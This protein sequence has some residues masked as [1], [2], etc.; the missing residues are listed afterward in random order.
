MPSNAVEVA[1]ASTATG[2]APTA[3]VTVWM[4]K[5]TAQTR[6]IAVAVSIVGV[7]IL[8]SLWAFVVW[9]RRFS[10]KVSPSIGFQ[11]SLSEERQAFRTPHTWEET[12]FD[13]HSARPFLNRPFSDAWRRFYPLRN[14][15][16]VPEP[17]IE[18][19]ASH[20][21]SLVE[22][23]HDDFQADADKL[24]TLDAAHTVYVPAPDDSETGPDV[25]KPLQHAG[26]HPQLVVRIPERAPSQA[27]VI[28]STPS[29]PSPLPPTPPP[30][31]RHEQ[32]TSGK[33]P[34]SDGAAKSTPLSVRQ[35]V[36]SV[37]TMPSRLSNTA[38][39]PDTARGS[40]VYG[41][42]S[43]RATTAGY[44]TMTTPTSTFF[45][46][47]F[48]IPSPSYPALPARADSI[49]TLKLVPNR[50]PDMEIPPM[51]ATAPLERHVDP[52][53]PASSPVEEETSGKRRKWFIYKNKADR[54]PSSRGSSDVGSSRS[55]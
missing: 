44:S 35:R 34:K 26:S 5:P 29:T 36:P 47:G 23:P 18:V 13:P 4:N 1:E 20:V 27:S 42:N 52:I 28:I 53:A 49:R 31:P 50:H 10:R 6:A 15:I 12:S 54:T 38:Q 22:P 41:S 43:E 46:A 48:Y 3:T 51:P 25:Q 17:Q 37:A 32:H 14:E 8:A 24:Y 55:A 40:G 2:S 9:L 45:P 30:K 21:A 11:A 39:N 19:Y 16:P 33:R 7:V